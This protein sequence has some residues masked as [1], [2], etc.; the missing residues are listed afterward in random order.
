MA[1]SNHILSA[2]HPSSQP[3]T[4]WR[5]RVEDLNGTLI[6]E[7]MVWLEFHKLDARNGLYST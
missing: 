7:E 5:R 3:G 4:G 6:D 2:I 1:T